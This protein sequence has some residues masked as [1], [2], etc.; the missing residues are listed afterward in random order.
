MNEIIKFSLRPKLKINQIFP[1]LNGCY[2]NL[3]GGNLNDAMQ[4]FTGGICETIRV[5]DRS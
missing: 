4:D 2:E 5:E 3:D 1:R